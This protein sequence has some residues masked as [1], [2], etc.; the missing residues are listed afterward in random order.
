M[1]PKLVADF[2]ILH[3]T[4]SGGMGLEDQNSTSDAYLWV[5]R[6]IRE[7]AHFDTGAL[8]SAT[9]GHGVTLVAKGPSPLF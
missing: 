2:P 5:A 9:H 1:E 6:R 7:R 3:L 4:C 8:G